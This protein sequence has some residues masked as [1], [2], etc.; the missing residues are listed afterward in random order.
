MMIS[1]C[2]VIICWLAYKL[3]CVFIKLCEM[4]E[5]KVRYNEILEY[6]RYELKAKHL[7]LLENTDEEVF[8]Q[9]KKTTQR[10]L[11]QFALHTKLKRKAKKYICG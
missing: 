3:L 7:V 11:D 8:T 6:M 9:W 2:L 10:Y 4:E 1:I 5:I